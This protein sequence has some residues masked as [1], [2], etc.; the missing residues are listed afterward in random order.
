MGETYH[1]AMGQEDEVTTLAV[2]KRLASIDAG[3]VTKNIG[4][5]SISVARL[6]ESQSTGS[7]GGGCS[8]T[9][10]QTRTLN[11]E[12]D[13]DGIVALSSNEFTPISGDYV[14]MA[15]APAYYCGL[16]RLRLYNV[17]DDSSVFAGPN[18]QSIDN[19]AGD[20]VTH[21]HLH[22]VF[23]A[24]GTDAYRIDHYTELTKATDGLGLAADDGGDE[25]FT[26]LL[27][28]KIG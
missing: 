26:D 7:D 9:T 22:Y 28:L 21:A 18:A 2:G 14:L 1:I 16:H 24:N 25:I 3:I 19:A 23:T 4:I 6:Y 27:L 8:A 15:T 17:T 5:A 11:T 13:T 12:E 10:W 20:E